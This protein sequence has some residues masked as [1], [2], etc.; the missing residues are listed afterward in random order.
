MPV[1]ISLF[2]HTPKHPDV[3]YEVTRPIK[4]LSQKKSFMPSRMTTLVRPS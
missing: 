4:T 3:L 1:P 2:H